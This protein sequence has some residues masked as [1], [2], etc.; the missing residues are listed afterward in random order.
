MIYKRSKKQITVISI[1]LAGMVPYF[2]SA[3][4]VF[5]LESDPTAFVL[6]GYSLHGGI[7]L[8]KIRIQL[9]IFRATVPKGLRKNSDF[10]VEQQGYGIKLDYYG[11]NP[12]G[13]FGGLEY[14]ITDKTYTLSAKDI[15]EKRQANLVGIRAGYKYKLSKHFYITPWISIKRTISDVSAIEIS[16]ETYKDD[17]WTFF[18]AVHLGVQF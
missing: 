2:A 3:S 17:K 5:Y 13:L 14:G 18:P 15:Q 11:N 12:Q 9:G 7:E 10:E 16:G 8:E 6:N 4:P 1:A